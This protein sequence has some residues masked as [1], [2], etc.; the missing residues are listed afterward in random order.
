MV[1]N[2]DTTTHLNGG[3]VDRSLVG[4][5]LVRGTWAG[6]SLVRGNSRGLGEVA[7]GF[8]GGSLADA[9]DAI[10]TGNVDKDFSQLTP[11]IDRLAKADARDV[12]EVAA[13]Q[14]QLMMGHHKIALSQSRRCFSWALVA[15]GTGVFFFIVAALSAIVM[16]SF[17]TPLVLFLSGAVIEGVAA[18][19]FC[20]YRRTAA[21]LSDF[22]DTL[23]WTQRHVLANSI[24]EGLSGETKEQT[25]ADLARKIANI[26][27]PSFLTTPPQQ[28]SGGGQT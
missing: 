13:S 27:N 8:G 24:C 28:S 9:L 16:S 3:S 22:H 10:A 25:R 2:H 23:G 5:G 17:V 18:L 6:G 7:R 1:N 4:G 12:Q 14:L 19:L 21:E 11:Y 20:L 26:H 15:A